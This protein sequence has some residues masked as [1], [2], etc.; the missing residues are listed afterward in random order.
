MQMLIL[1]IVVTVLTVRNVMF[2][3]LVSIIEGTNVLNR[4]GRS[5]GSFIFVSY[6]SIE[7]ENELNNAPHSSVWSLT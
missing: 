2:K 1:H 4:I 3:I 7:M 6:I 5:V